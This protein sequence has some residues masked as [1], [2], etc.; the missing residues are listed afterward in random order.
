ME[1]IFRATASRVRDELASSAWS[2]ARSLSCDVTAPVAKNGETVDINAV[3]L[4][5]REHFHQRQFNISIKFFQLQF[6]KL[7]R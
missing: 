6:S 2:R 4:H 3:L 5:S 1:N 7:S